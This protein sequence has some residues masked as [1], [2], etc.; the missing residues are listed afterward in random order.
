VS[1]AVRVEGVVRALELRADPHVGRAVTLVG[2]EFSSQSSRWIGSSRSSFPGSPLRQ[3]G[4]VTL[5]V[6]KLRIGGLAP[7]SAKHNSLQSPVL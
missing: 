6:V 4:A 1:T 5:Q 3:P 7:S 2:G